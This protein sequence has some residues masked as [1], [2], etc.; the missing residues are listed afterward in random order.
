MR[1]RG[2]FRVLIRIPRLRDSI[3]PAPRTGDA[4][5]AR[6]RVE[7]AG[8]SASC[9]KGRSDRAM[10][11]F[12]DKVGFIWS[13]ADLLRGDYKPSEYGRVIL[14]LVTLRR[15]DCVLAPT[16]EAVLAEDDA[17]KG[18]GRTTPEAVLKRVARQQFSNSSKLD[19]PS[20]WP[21]PRRSPAACAVTST[22]SAPRPAR[23]SRSSRSRNI[24]SAS[25][26][27]IC[28]T[29]CCNA[30]RRSIFIPKRSPIW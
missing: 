11:G 22:A 14:P 6:E 18:S 28:S 24:S 21:T 9:D 12:G 10:E 3:S 13:V 2:R 4:R 17:W 29:G 30:S 20:C 19:F 5:P 23:P 16:K 27:P 1:P 25:N 26:G 7:W 8:A 15:L